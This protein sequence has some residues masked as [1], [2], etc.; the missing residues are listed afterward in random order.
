MEDGIMYPTMEK[1]KNLYTW[2]DKFD[3]GEYIRKW[4]GFEPHYAGCFYGDSTV[5]G[6]EEKYRKCHDFFSSVGDVEWWVVEEINK[7]T[8]AEKD[9]L[10][11]ILKRN[12]YFAEVIRTPDRVK[13]LADFLG[14]VPQNVYRMKNKELYKIFKIIFDWYNN[15]CGKGVGKCLV[16]DQLTRA[17]TLPAIGDSI[18]VPSMVEVKYFRGNEVVKSAP[19]ITFEHSVGMLVM[20][21]FSKAGLYENDV[22]QQWITKPNQMSFF[23][24]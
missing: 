21:G 11:A 8:D 4:R 16:Y 17:P 3:S 15:L 20:Y 19:F 2:Q 22:L 13:S 6:G 10:E 12:Q 5:L 14:V 18:N 24:C 1:Q 9:E 23:N 7:L